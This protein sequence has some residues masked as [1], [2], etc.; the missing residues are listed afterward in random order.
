MNIINKISKEEF[1][2]LFN[3]CSSIKD[4]LMSLNLRPFSYNYNLLH[5]RI[6]KENF[7]LEIFSKNCLDA[8]QQRLLVLKKTKSLDLSEVFTENAKCARNIVKRILISNKLIN[9]ECEVCKNPGIHLSKKLSL[10]IDHKNGIYND[11]RLENLRWLCP[12]CHSQTETYSGKNNK[13]K[14]KYYCS[15]CNAEIKGFSKICLKCARKNNRKFHISKEELENMLFVDKQNFTNIGN[16]L[17]VSANSIKKRCKSFG[18]IFSYSPK[19][20]I[21]LDTN[22][23]S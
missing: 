22:P 13:D 17:G 12:N 19:G 5:K 4:V 6:D 14:Q 21:L 8:R 2:Q 9:Y 1:Q 3:N 11:N 23:K 15:N 10:Q 7:D 20:R 16:K 18:I